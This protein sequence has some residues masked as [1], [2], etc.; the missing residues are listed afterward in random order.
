MAVISVWLAVATQSPWLGAVL[1]VIGFPALLRVAAIGRFERNRQSHWGWS[2]RLVAILESFV[3][4]WLIMV[5]AGI[6]LIVIGF[7]VSIPLTIL[8]VPP[9]LAVGIALLVAAIAAGKL[10]VYL[11]RLSWPRV[12]K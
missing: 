6:A 7:L 4:M 8:Q 9:Q 1:A 10:I 12:K 3:I 5:A 2:E 11:V